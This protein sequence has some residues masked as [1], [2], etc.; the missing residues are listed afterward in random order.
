MRDVA[1]SMSEPSSRDINLAVYLLEKAKLD[2]VLFK[3]L[4]IWNV[5]RMKRDASDVRSREGLAALFD[6]IPAHVLVEAGLV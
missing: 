1:A 2:P 3:A 5:Q 6:G 4:E